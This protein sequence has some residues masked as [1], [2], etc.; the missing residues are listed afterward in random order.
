EEKYPTVFAI[1][2]RETFE[3]PNTWFHIDGGDTVPRSRTH[4]NSN[5]HKRKLDDSDIDP[6]EESSRKR[7]A[8][9][10]NEVIVQDDDLIMTEDGPQRLIVI[11]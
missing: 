1:S 4:A 5:A 7:P 9:I 8:V 2:H 11:D 3:S 6:Q 10:E